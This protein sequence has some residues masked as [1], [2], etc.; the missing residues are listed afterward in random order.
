MVRSR[1]EEAQMETR[2]LRIRI[3]EGCRVHEIDRGLAE[4]ERLI[5]ATARNP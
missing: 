1:L 3:R 4:I 5:V 2:A